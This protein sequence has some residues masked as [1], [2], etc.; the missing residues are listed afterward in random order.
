MVL[1]ELQNV[2]PP[3]HKGFTFSRFIGDEEAS[4]I[5]LQILCFV[6]DDRVEISCLK[7]LSNVKSRTPAQRKVHLGGGEF[8][9]KLSC[10][11]HSVVGMVWLRSSVEARF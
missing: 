1:I 4:N 5:R 10:A 3:P 9:D 11:D 7:V 8:L 6:T 2:Y